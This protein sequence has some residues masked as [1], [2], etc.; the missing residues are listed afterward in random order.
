MASPPS[1]STTKRTSRL[2]PWSRGAG[3]SA[4][5]SADPF[6]VAEPN[7]EFEDFAVVELA[8]GEALA[9]SAVLW[10]LDRHNRSAHVGISLLPS[11]RGRG[12]G[13]DAVK[14]MCEYGFAIR[15]FN[16]LAIET[17]SDNA[18]MLRAA[19]RSGFVREGLLR[20]AAWVSGHFLDE[21]V[22]GLLAEDWNRAKRKGPASEPKG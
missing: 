8:E 15:G 9:G 21:V 19:E 4:G 22:L 11:C 20:Q 18:P 6:R 5:S 1:C 7:D 12:L 2:L 10:G 17:F 14:V 16:R 13:L 3:C